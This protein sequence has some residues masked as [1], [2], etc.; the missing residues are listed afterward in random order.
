MA[1]EDWFQDVFKVDTS[2]NTEQGAGSYSGADYDAAFAQ[3][4]GAATGGGD[5]GLLQETQ[6]GAPSVAAS[7]SYSSTTGDGTQGNA[8]ILNSVGT[9]AS[10]AASTLKDWF[11][12]ATSL[13]TEPETTRRVQNKETGQYEDVTSAGGGLNSLGKLLI[14]GA[15]QS[16]GQGS[17]LK[18]QAERASKEKA[19]DRAAV[20]AAQNEKYRRAAYGGAPQLNAKRRG[21]G[22]LGTG[23]TE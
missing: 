14:A 4:F 10:D 13:F 23:G 15:I 12:K 8:D 7:A 17:V 11:D 18:W 19:K 9:F 5:G 21:S 3:Q 16:L 1:Y 20:L 22:L 2:G 6:A